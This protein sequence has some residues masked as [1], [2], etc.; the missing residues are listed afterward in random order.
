MLTP[1]DKNEENDR[2]SSCEGVE[3]RPLL[4]G[5]QGSQLGTRALPDHLLVLL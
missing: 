4:A 2:E 3:V 1:K 5:S